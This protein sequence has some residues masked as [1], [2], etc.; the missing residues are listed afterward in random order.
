MESIDLVRTEGTRGKVTYQK[1]ETGR[2]YLDLY[3]KMA[4]LLDPSISAPALI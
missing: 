4:L 1:T 3:N 2:D